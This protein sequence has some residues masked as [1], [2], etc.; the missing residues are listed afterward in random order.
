M[1]TNREDPEPRPPSKAKSARRSTCHAIPVGCP[2]AK[3]C[4]LATAGTGLVRPV[5]NKK[6]SNRPPD[7]PSEL[8]HLMS[9]KLREEDIEHYSHKVEHLRCLFTCLPRIKCEPE[10]FYLAL[11]AR[12]RLPKRS[13]AKA[14]REAK[15]CQFW[16]TDTIQE[17]LVPS[18]ATPVNV[19]TYDMKD[20]LISCVD[21]YCELAQ[22]SRSSLKH[23][24]TPFHE[25][26]I[27]KLVSEAEPQGLRT[28]AAHR[29]PG[30]NEDLVCCQDGQ[31]GPVEGNTVSCI[32]NHHMV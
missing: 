27:G 11:A 29:Q 9:S 26:R 30:F 17:E 3:P 13:K 21:K 2:T 10:E 28:L 24:S 19:V 18:M 31:M 25:N 22:V 15:Q 14:K 32:E 8:W 7:T 1:M 4:L 23:V 16:G 20:F 5:R 12:T 6:G